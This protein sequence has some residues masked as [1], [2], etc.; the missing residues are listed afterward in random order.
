MTAIEAIEQIMKET[1]SS[2]SFLSEYA[3]LGTREN[4]Y[5]MLHRND[6]KVGTFVKLAE[7]MG[8]QLVLCNPETDEDIIIDYD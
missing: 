1:D 3:D 2:F 4:I 8:Y 5:Q 7:V 6:L